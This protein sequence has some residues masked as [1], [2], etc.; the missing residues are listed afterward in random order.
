[1]VEE[2]PEE[3]EPGI[4]RRR[5]ARIGRDIRNEEHLNVVRCAKHAI[6]AGARDPRS[7]AIRRHRCGVG[8]GLI[9]NQ[10]RDDAWL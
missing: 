8:R 1:V 4:E 2:L 7:A 6:K 5:Q 10:I 9:D 3:R